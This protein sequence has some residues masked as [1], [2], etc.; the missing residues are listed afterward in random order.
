[1]KKNSC[2]KNREKAGKK[3]TLNPKQ[4]VRGWRIS[5][6]EKGNSKRK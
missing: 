3:E 5:R 4:K 6:E 2:G 1:V